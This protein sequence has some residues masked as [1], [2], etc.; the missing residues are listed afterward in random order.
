MKT[1]RLSI[2]LFSLLPGCEPPDDLDRADDLDP[3][4]AWSP[5]D[6]PS[7]LAPDFV[8]ALS[9]LPTAGSA[10]QLPWPGPY[11]PTWRDSINDRWAGAGVPS[12]AEKFEQAFARDGFVEAVSYHYGIDSLGGEFCSTHTDCDL[13]GGFVCGK[14]RGEG[15]GTC[16]ESWF[17]LCHAWAPAAVLEP[18]PVHPVSYGGVQF[19]V[20]DL[21]ALVTLAYDDDLETRSVSLRCDLKGGEGDGEPQCDDTNAGTFHVVV[22]NLLGLRGQAFIEDRTY[23]YQVWNYPVFAFNVTQLDAIDGKQANQLLG[24]GPVV[25]SSLEQG[26]AGANALAQ[27]GSVA[28]S[29]GQTLRV[30]LSGTGDLDLYVRWNAAPTLAA[31][32][33]RPYLHGSDEQ[34][35]L[36]VPASATKAFVAAHAYGVA[37]DYEARI[38][39][40]AAPTATYAYN[41]KAKSL[42]RVRTELAF[43]G[44]S[45]A[46]RDGAQTGASEFMFKDVYDYVLEL[47]GAGKIIGG[48]WIGDS[49]ITH[50][51]F[52]WRPI[53]KLSGTVAGGKL[54]WSDVQELLAAA[55]E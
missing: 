29:P 43:V 38:T 26:E 17:G 16:I 44:E 18:E 46:E 30:H 49:K 28:V 14:R 37:A 19:A 39:V 54:A 35:E 34:C 5:Y 47:D 8:Y 11:W 32:H 12:P 36:L 2:L 6:R 13:A 53:K 9:A 40:R 25:S 4:R 7:L 24:G 31:Y 42:R 20:N 48:E 10:E 23:D 45:P 55:H 21:K 27:L 1:S 3:R 41:A 15:W 51:D 22:A 52:L 50:P 33:C